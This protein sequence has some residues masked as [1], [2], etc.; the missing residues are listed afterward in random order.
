MGTE[1]VYY[2]ILNNI[3]LRKMLLPRKL[4]INLIPFDVVAVLNVV[5]VRSTLYYRITPVATGF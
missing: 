4:V 1:I 5:D 2:V 3:S